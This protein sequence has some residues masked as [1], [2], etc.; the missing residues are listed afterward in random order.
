MTA[1]A[2]GPQPSATSDS[3][4]SV[5]GLYDLFAAAQGASAPP[6]VAAFAELAEPGMHVLDVG[7]GTG[8]VAL[9][10]A[11]RGA[12]VWCVEPS[13][14]MRSALLAKLAGRPALWPRLTVVAGQAPHL[15]PLGPFDYAYLAGSLQFLTATDRLATFRELATRLRPDARLAV[16]MIDDG[17]TDLDLGSTVRTLATVQAGECRYSMSAA[18]TDVTS[19]AAHIQYRYV[20]EQGSKRT[21]QSMLRWRY[22]HPFA[23]VHADLVTA[24]FTLPTGLDGN[25]SRPSEAADVLIARRTS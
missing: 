20:T 10:V 8:R 22:F 11:E 23:D 3:Y 1:S 21:E 6:H 4:E 14:S 9:A 17:R 5:A 18:V 7:A 24:G 25:G 2:A 19:G 15:G 12:H 13:A 16:D